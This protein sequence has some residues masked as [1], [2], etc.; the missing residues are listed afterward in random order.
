MFILIRVQKFMQQN[1]TYVTM[2]LATI[3]YLDFREEIVAPRSF[4]IFK[5][6]L[7]H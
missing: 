5:I 4:F 1:V 2:G 6:I 3:R 7:R